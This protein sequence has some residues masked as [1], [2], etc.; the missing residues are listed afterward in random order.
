MDYNASLDDIIKKNKSKIGLKSRNKN[1]KNKNAKPAVRT[2]NKKKQTPPPAFKQNQP[3]FKAKLKKRKIID[4]PDARMKIIQNKKKLRRRSVENTRSPLLKDARLKIEARRQKQRTPP[5]RALPL[6]S[7]LVSRGAAV[8][9]LAPNGIIH[10]RINPNMARDNGIRVEYEDD[11]MM[12]LE[13]E[14]IARSNW[15]EKFTLRRTISNPVDRKRFPPTLM[16]Y[17]DLDAEPEEQEYYERNSVP[18]NELTRTITNIKAS[19]SL[20]RNYSSRLSSPVRQ[21]S[22]PIR[23]RSPPIRQRSPPVRQ[24][25]S[26]MRQSPID[27]MRLPPPSK[28]SYSARE[29]NYSSRDN[30]YSSRDNNYPPRDNNYSSRD[31]N[32]PP[33]D[34]NYSSRDSSY[35]PR[36]SS[37]SSRDSN[38]LSR[39]TGYPSREPN[40]YRIMISNLHE[41]VTTEDIKELFEDIGD[42]VYTRMRNGTAEVAYKH[43]KDAENA[44]EI[45]HNRQLDGLPMK[46]TLITNTSESPNK[47]RHSRLPPVSTKSSIEPDTSLIKKALFN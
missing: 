12:S 21:R 38:Y 36:D 31:N 25:S 5:P 28:S 7:N 35:P 11:D 2:S 19:P 6:R 24:R 14:P 8:T 45:Y 43:Q 20:R 47:K 1:W 42:L 34:S 26:P 33:R 17:R 44:V 23:Q 15:T 30:N 22:S 40:Y 3:A 4:V 29:S 16:G 10:R 13:N 37:Y 9:S 18:F 46:C 32:Y 41:K 39:D 27:D